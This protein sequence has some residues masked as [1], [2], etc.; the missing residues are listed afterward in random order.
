MCLAKARLRES[1]V[2]GAA[3]ACALAIGAYRGFK[4]LQ[5]RLRRAETPRMLIDFEEMCAH[6][7]GAFEPPVRVAGGAVRRIA[8]IVARIPTPRAGH[9]TRA[10]DALDALL[11]IGQ[12]ETSHPIASQVIKQLAA[13]LDSRVLLHYEGGVY[14]HEEPQAVH[15]LSTWTL[16]RLV[17]EREVRAR[18]VRAAP[19]FWLPEQ[20][21]PAGVLSVP[22]GDGVVVLARGR[23][24]RRREVAAVRA[25][26][27]FL[28]LR[29]TTPSHV[30]VPRLPPAPGRAALPTVS[31][32][33]VGTS[34]AWEGVLHQVRRIA[35]SD[36]SIVLLGET[37]SGKERLARAIHAYSD[38]AHGA[39]V[40][41]NCGVVPHELIASELFGHIRGAFTGADRNRD[42]LFVQAHKGTLFLDEVAEMPL[43]MQVALLRV[44]EDRRVTPVGSTRPREVDVRI[45][46]ATN[47][48]LGA[49]VDAGQFRE[50]LWHRLNVFVLRVP[51]LRERQADLPLLANHILA[52]L[53]ERKTL[54]PDACEVLSRYAWPGNVRELENVLRAACLLS[55]GPQLTPDMLDRMLE[56]R[57][58][59]RAQIAAP[60][61]PPRSQAIL[62]TIGDRWTSAGE[63]AS[64]LGA[65]LRTVNREIADLLDRGLLRSSG[66][67]R[68]SRYQCV[69]PPWRDVARS[70]PQQPTP[71]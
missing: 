27:R 7:L 41:V 43:A 30:P 4:R 40:P 37:G 42:G 1:D 71:P 8:R 52:R 58:E 66:Q 23:K 34:P 60:R 35:P 36:C 44:L 29:L 20:R 5:K 21:R 15:T 39:F 38:R 24:Y 31:E 57:R 12:S 69:R 16:R 50:D 32:G 11:S 54:H 33:L 9:P 18:A 22:I 67:A 17:A 63:V 48:D 45:V 19:E 10:I 14:V 25:V 65:S 6:V 46:S 28:K 47:V 56:S 53:P 70:A 49:R 61:L 59:A 26:L 64:A 55:D 51:P 62:Q 13:M 3:Q 68:A 2:Q